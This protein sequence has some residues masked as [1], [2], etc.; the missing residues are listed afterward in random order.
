MP[1]TI[2]FPQPHKVVTQKPSLRKYLT[3]LL[4]FGPGAV[5]ASMTIGQAQFIIGPQIGSWAGYRLL[6]LI[7]LNVGS[8]IIAYVS[9]RFTMLS[10]VSLMDIFALK[11]RRGWLNWLFIGIILFFVPLFAAAIITTLGQTLA[12]IF[13]VGHYLLW[14]I[15]FC[16]VALLLVLIGRYRLLE[17]TQAFFVAVLGVGAVISVLVIRPDLLDVIPHF[18]TF[19]DVPS[20]P[21]WVDQVEGFTR[22]PIPVVM[23]GYLGTLT[24][25]IIPLV[26]YLGWIKVKRWGIFKDKENPDRFQ[27]GLFQRFKNKGRID[28]LPESDSEHKKAR[29]L[30]RP[31]VV[32]LAIALVIVSVVSIAYM[33]AG[34]ALFRPEHIIPTDQ[35]LLTNQKEIFVQI[36]PEAANLLTPLYQVSIGFALFGTVYAGFEAAARMVHETGRHVNVI[37]RLPYRRFLVYLMVYVLGL[38]ILLSL[39]VYWGI[40]VLLLLSLTLL[41]IG[42]VGVVIYGAGAVYM[43]QRVLPERYRLNRWQLAVAIVSVLM[44]LVPLVAFAA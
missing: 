4:F 37:G 17:H 35:D 31:I 38:G 14:G 12:W 2:S 9:C 44:L 27:E 11:T 22:T 33:V 29:L 13:G 10:G 25:T 30:L 8:Y 16:T 6:W 39:L 36:A 20:Y 43:T 23:L 5:L 28:Y 19:G 3:Y 34:A 32:D 40:S 24:V 15:G 1:E 42:V 21:A 41:F 26:G 18:F 7:T